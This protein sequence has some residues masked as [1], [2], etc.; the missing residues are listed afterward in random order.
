M[1]TFASP[2]GLAE[3]EYTNV[4]SVQV[5]HLL[6]R[7]ISLSNGSGSRVRGAGGSRLLSPAERSDGERRGVTDS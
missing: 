1:R 6:L 4:S 5:T 7:A 3:V 2:Q